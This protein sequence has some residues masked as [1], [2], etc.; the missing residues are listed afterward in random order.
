MNGDNKNPFEFLSK[1]LEPPGSN[2]LR[3][4]VRIHSGVQYQQIHAF[5]TRAIRPA[6]S[7]VPKCVVSVWTLPEIAPV[8]QMVLL[9]GSRGMFPY[10]SVPVDR[11]D[12]MAWSFC[13][14]IHFREFLAFLDSSCRNNASPCVSPR[15]EFAG[16]VSA[17]AIEQ[18]SVNLE[19]IREAF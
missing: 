8:E 4:M 17:P 18:L 12:S 10:D 14:D 16:Q 9:Q 7:A 15:R 1:S 13:R 5:W 6:E 11:T 19:P 2:S 3:G